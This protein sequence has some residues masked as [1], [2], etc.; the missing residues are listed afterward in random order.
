MEK[1]TETV[2]IMALV[3]GT[4]AEQN[5]KVNETQQIFHV[6]SGEL[7]K[8]MNEM[9]ILNNSV[10][11]LEKTKVSLVGIIENLSALS[12]ENAAATQEASESLNSQLY[13]AQEVAAA[14]AG[15]SDLAQNMIEMINKFKI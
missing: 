15:L 6:I 13:S 3:G 2:D 7:D 8:N 14:S 4:V 11:E 5:E 9:S 12:E 1:V 10:N